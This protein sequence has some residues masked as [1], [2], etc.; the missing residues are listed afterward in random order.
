MGGLENPSNT[1]THQHKETNS[2]LATYIHT[3]LYTYITRTLFLIRT[4]S[5]P[6]KCWCFL[7]PSSACNIT[8]AVPAIS[9][10][11]VLAIYTSYSLCVWRSLQIPTPS[12]IQLLCMLSNLLKSKICEV[13]D[14]PIDTIKCCCNLIGVVQLAAATQWLTDH[15]G[16]IP[17]TAGSNYFC[18]PIISYAF[19]SWEPSTFI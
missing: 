3:I 15:K 8:I 4:S 11:I 5:M 7:A 10:P 1:T 19:T 13:I 17:H 6:I 9:G 14:K 16:Y 18:S 12:Y 2:T